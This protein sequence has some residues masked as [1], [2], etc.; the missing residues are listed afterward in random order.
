MRR[1]HLSTGLLLCS[2]AAWGQQAGAPPATSPT[3]PTSA[4]EKTTTIAL[5]AKLVS[6]PVV[7]RDKKGA[8]V[9]TLNKEDF[10]LQ[11]DGKTQPIRY[12]DKDDDLP[13]TLGLLVDTSQSQRNVLDEERTASEGFLD[14]MLGTRTVKATPVAASDKAP[15]QVADRAFVIQF[16][17]QVELLQD[18]TDSKPKLKAALRELDTP[19]FSGNNSGNGSNNGNGNG[20]DDSQN[21]GA[22]RGGRQG[23]GT[24]LYDAV[25]LSSHE[26][27]IKEHGRKAIVV[28]T[29]GDDRGSK[30]SLTD[31]IEAAQRADT[32][33]YAIYFKGQSPGT[34]N[35]RGGYPG[36]GGR[37]G[38]GFPGGGGGYPGGGGGGY[39]GG[40]GG[41][42]GY[43]RGG[44]NGGGSGV[45]GKRVLERMADETGGRMFEVKGKDT[46]TSIYTQI[47]EELRSQYRLGYSPDAA[48]AADGYHQVTVTVPKEKN[49]RIQTRDGYYTGVQ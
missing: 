18:L 6:L 42:G 29:D 40:G 39:P 19:S 23:G 7:V 17:R 25:Y 27:L 32:I 8:I 41:G 28:L 34:N 11:V 48:N 43:P 36:G 24:A 21:S 47:A 30:K 1:V 26:V 15:A 4:Q 44:G 33:I 20:S 46:V 37:H 5:D 12:F 16:A 45:D 13:L 9:R 2:L 49:D 38:G 3:T 14:G 35:N 22:S 31:A 10:M